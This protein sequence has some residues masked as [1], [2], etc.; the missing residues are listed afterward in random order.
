M[1]RDIHPTKERLIVTACELLE[2]N[3]PDTIQVEQLL[4]LSGIS[5]G[6]LYHHF[7]DL[8]EVL[9]VAQ[10]RRYAQRAEA[11]IEG[12][13]K[14]I[15]NAK[16]KEEFLNGLDQVTMSSQSPANRQFRME[17]SGIIALSRGNAR[18]QSLLSQTQQQITD[19]LAD[20]V[21]EAQ[22]RGW[23]TNEISATSLSVFIQAY[24]L[25]RIVDDVALNQV[26]SDEWNG[27]LRRMLLTAFA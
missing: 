5:K 2:T 1:A 18:L 27:L 9:E 3:R 20:L 17:R 7:E 24:T 16:D 12:I 21:Y 23:I 11:D 13:S 6:S 15:Y 8:A 14:I 10:V 19:A 22:N 25:G 4:Q 26:D